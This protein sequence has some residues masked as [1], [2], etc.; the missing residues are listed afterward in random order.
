VRRN[1]RQINKRINIFCLCK[2]NQLVNIRE[3]V[4]NTKPRRLGRRPIR[5]DIAHGNDLDTR[6]LG[7]LRQVLVYSNA[8]QTNDHETDVSR[9]VPCHLALQIRRCD[10]RFTV[11]G[12]FR[13]DVQRSLAPMNPEDLVKAH[14]RRTCL[15]RNRRT[16]AV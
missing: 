11:S 4:V 5:P 3:D 13:N 8:T 6:H 10:N 1:A 9:R 2:C 16:G 15:R 12:K 14:R 7:D